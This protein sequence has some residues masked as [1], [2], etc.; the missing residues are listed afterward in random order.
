M[1]PF[2]ED[3]EPWKKEW[4]GMPEFVHKD[5]TPYRSIIV[6][7]KTKQDVKDF[8]NLINQT[9]YNKTQSIWY[10]KV[11][12]EKYMNKRYIDES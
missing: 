7:F 3:L 6:H 12:I 2:F 8:A 9:I 5:L 11:V 10:P 4:Q 1:K